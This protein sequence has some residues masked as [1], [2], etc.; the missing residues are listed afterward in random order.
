MEAL[1]VSPKFKQFK[2]YYIKALEEYS[3]TGFNIGTA[4]EYMGR[5]DYDTSN[6]YIVKAT[7][8]MKTATEY[9]NKANELLP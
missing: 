2:Y 6:E 9:L 5:S 1:T 3:K 8:N 4:G 7:K